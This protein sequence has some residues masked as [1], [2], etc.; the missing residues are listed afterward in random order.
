[1][2]IRNM[3]DSIFSGKLN[4]SS[5]T[6]KSIIA[7]KV[8]NKLDEMK[9]EVAS[10]ICSEDTEDLDENLIKGDVP[11]SW[12][13]YRRHRDG[14]VIVSSGR[15]KKP[16]SATIDKL[17]N[18]YG[19][20]VHYSKPVTYSTPVKEEVD[21]LE[22]LSKDTY[23]NYIKSA[24]ND[25]NYKG[26]ASGFRAGLKDPTHNTSDEHPAVVKHREGIS[27]ALRLLAKVSNKHAPTSHSH[28]DHIPHGHNHK[29]FHEESY[30][31]DEAVGTAAKYADKT[32]FMGGKYKSTDKALELTGDKFNAWRAKRSA[33]KSAEHKDQDPKLAAAGYGKHMVD[34][35]KAKKNAESPMNSDAIQIFSGISII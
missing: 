12:N 7:E 24:Y 14:D 2:S 32:G 11:V 22:E 5:D 19:S 18:K 4:E 9:V 25:A 3:L 31:L 16:S 6:F 28:H 10:T 17:D 13:I 8:Q 35:E 34:I 21:S 20:Y 27:K 33:K 30:E 26:N 15:K 29:D 23:T 1:M